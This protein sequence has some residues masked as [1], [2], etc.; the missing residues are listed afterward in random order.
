MN[1]NENE[2]R[3][4][5]PMF[6]VLPERD[7]VI[8]INDF[9]GDEYDALVA[10]ILK[11]SESSR[12]IGSFIA[13]DFKEVIRFK[14]HG[15]YGIGCYEGVA[16]DNK[17]RTWFFMIIPEYRAYDVGMMAEDHLEEFMNKYVKPVLDTHGKTDDPGT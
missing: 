13:F 11:N 10:K 2:L 15:R 3:R 9:D 1:L 12:T 4:G 7:K 16:K 8:E 17:G 6:G 14:T 5:L